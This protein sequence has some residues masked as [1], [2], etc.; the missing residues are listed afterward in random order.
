MPKY[1]FLA[2][3]LSE[4]LLQS[5]MAGRPAI[6]SLSRWISWL[7]FISCI[8]L[9]SIGRLY[10]HLMIKSPIVLASIMIFTLW[11]SPQSY[12]YLVG[13]LF[14]GFFIYILFRYN[15]K[16]QD[17]KSIWHIRC[18]SHFICLDF[19]ALHFILYV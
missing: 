8:L 4:N 15:N 1:I 19:P 17:A 16:C 18:Y 7:L 2:Y 14:V 5:R 11:L 6:F 13:F 3:H 10:S 12:S 9:T